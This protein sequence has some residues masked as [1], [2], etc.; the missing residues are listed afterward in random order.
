MDEEK[1]H[2]MNRA[3]SNFYCFT[4]RLCTQACAGDSCCTGTAATTSSRSALA[5]PAT[6]LRVA[7]VFLLLLFYGVQLQAQIGIYQFTGPSACPHANVAVTAQPA[8]ASFSN[9]RNQGGSCDSLQDIFNISNWNTNAT[10]NLSEYNEFTLT[11]AGGYLLDLTS[12]SF[13]QLATDDNNTKWCLRSSVDN[14]S[15]DIASGTAGKTLRNHNIPLNA[16]FTC[17]SQATFRFYIIDAKDGGTKWMMDNVALNGRVKVN[18]ATPAVP[19][20]TSPLCQNPGTT[21]SFNGLPPGTDNWYWQTVPNGTGIAN[22]TANFLVTTPGVYYLRARNKT[23]LDWS[24]ETSSITIASLTPDVA[25]PVFALGTSSDRCMGA[26]VMNFAATAQFAS[27]I[28]YSLDSASM[29]A[30]NSIDSTTG[31]V[32]FDSAWTG[33][34]IITA[35]AQ[36]CNGPVSSQH[37]VVTALPVEAPVFTLS[38]TTKRCQGNET[39]T[40]SATALHATGI[41]YSLDTASLAAGNSINA[42]T[43]EV[44]FAAGWFGIST[45]TATANG[46]FGPLSTTHVIATTASVGVPVF[47]VGDSSTRCVGIET[48][49][50]PATATTATGISYSLDSVSVAGGNSIDSTTGDVVFDAAWTGTTIVTAT[51]YGC[52][53]PTSAIHTIIT[54][55]SVTEPRFDAGSSSGRCQ[56]NTPVLYPVIVANATSIA[57]TL[58]SGSIAAGITIDAATGRATYPASWAGTTYITVVAEG[59]YGPQQ[60]VHTAIT[61][62]TVGTPVF[63]N[64]DTSSRCQGTGVV[65]IEATATTTTGITYSLDAAS[66]AAGNTIDAVT[67]EVNF[68]SSYSGTA[69]IT[70]SAAGCNGPA[71]AV[72]LVNVITTVGV[73][74]FASGATSSRCIGANI[75]TYTA[76]AT[77]ST[78]ITYSLDSAS[79]AAGNTIDTATG[80]VTWSNNWFGGSIITATAFGCN[81]PSSSEHVVTTNQEVTLPVFAVGDTSVRCQ[82]SDVVAYTATA[83]HTTGIVYTLDAAS[84]AAGNIIDSINGSITYAANWS[85]ITVITATANGCAGPK[86]ATHTVTT[87]ATVGLPVFALGATSSRCQAAGTVT[88]SADA[89]TNTGITYSLDSVSAAA[90]N[91]IDSL[92]GE[93]TYD[94][95]WFGSTVITATATGCNGPRFSTHTVTTNAPVTIPSFGAGDSTVRCEGAANVFYTATAENNTN[96]TYSIDAASISGGVTRNV[97]SG[98]VSFPANWSGTTIVTA[99]ATGCYGP[100]NQQHVVTT[101]PTVDLP[102]FAAGNTSTR[103]QGADTITFEA[104][105]TNATGIYYSLNASSLS[106]GNSI[107]AGTGEVIFVEGY[108]GTT[109]ITA[110]ADG[111]NGPRTATHT[112]TVTA[113]VGTPVFG[114]GATSTRCQGSG[115]V[116]YNATA[117]TNTGIS[118]TLDSASLAAGNTINSSTG[119]VSFHPAWNG[120]SIVTAIATGCNGPSVNTHTVTITPTVG[121]PVFAL[122]ASSERCR[123]NGSIQVVASASNSTS[124]SYQLDFLSRFSGNTI[125]STTGVVTYVSGWNGTSTITATAQGCN[126]PVTAVHTL[127]TNNYVTTPVF[128]DGYTSSRCQAAGMLSYTASASNTT[129]ITYS[130]D[131][132]SLAG[133]NTI[134]PVS[135]AVTYDANWFGTTIITATAAGCSGPRSVTHT[136]TINAPVTVPAFTMGATSV[137]CQGN[138]GVTYT[139]TVDHQTNLSYSLDAASLAAGNTI[140]TSTGRVVYTGSFTGTSVITARA[141]GCYG[142]QLQTH[143]VTTTPTVGTPVFTGGSSSVRCQGAGSVVYGATST[144]STGITYSLDA[145]SIAGGNTIDS[146]SGSVTFATNWNGTSVITARATGCNG[147]RSATHTVTITPTV[148]TPVYAAGATS[149]RCQAGGNVSYNVSA[150]NNTGFIYTLDSASL[151][152]GN[153]INAA[154]GVLTYNANWTGNSV[155]SVV[156]LGCNGPSAT[157]SHSVTTTPIVGVPEFAKGASSVRCQGAAAV[158]FTATAT[159]ATGITYSLN[160]ASIA[161]GNTINASTGTVT[162]AATWTGNSVITATAAGCSGPSVSVHTV[163]TTPTVGLPVF[164][165]GSSSSRCQAAGSTLYTANSTNNTGITYSLDGASIAGGNTINMT[166]GEVAY[167]AGWYGTTVVTATATGCNGP[168]SA[169]HTVVTNAPVTIPVFVL[170]GASTRCQGAGTVNYPAN[171]MHTTGIT[172]TLDSA[173]LAGGNTINAST[174]AVTY[175]AGWSGTSTITA[176]AAGCYGPQVAVH[177][178]TIT[179]TVGL[180]VFSSGST[181]ARCQGVE[182]ISYAAT[183]TN[184]TSIIYTL[185]GTSLSGGNTINSTTGVLTFAANWSGSSIITATA[186]G[187]NGPRSAS[188]VVATSAPVTTPVFAS[189]ATSTRCQGAGTINYS[190]TANNTTGITYMLDASS[191]AA[192]NTI[193]SNTGALT[194]TA[195]WSGTSIVTATA[196]GCYGPL[197]ATHIVTITPSVGTPFFTMG[198]TSSRCNGAGTVTYTATA[199]TNTGLTYSLDAGSIAAGNSINASTGTVTYVTGWVGIATITARATGCN[200]PITSIHRATSTPSVAVPV[201]T[202]GATSN[203]CQGAGMVT[204]QANAANST[205]I[206]YTIDGTSS[207]NGCTIDAS[208]GRVTYAAD[209]LGITTIT[210]TANGCNGPTVATHTVTVNPNGAPTFVLGPNSSRIQGAANVPFIANANNGSTVTYSLDAISLA[211]GNTINATTGVV[212]FHPL[213]IGFSEIT[214]TATG[215][216]GPVSATHTVMSASSTVTKQLY[217]SDPLHAL[218]RIDPV[219]TG[220]NTLATTSILSLNSSSI[221]IDNASSIS[222]TGSS[223]TI[224]HTTGS[225]PDRLMMV[226]ITYKSNGSPTS[227][228][229][230]QYV[231]YGGVVMNRVGTTQ[232]SNDRAVAIFSILNPAPGTAD[233]EVV[234]DIATTGAIIGVTTFTGVNQ[235]T[236]LNTFATQNGTNSNPSLT[237]ASA[238]NELVFSVVGANNTITPVNGDQRWLLVQSGLYGAGGTHPGAASANVSY[239]V[240]GLASLRSWI[241]SGISIRPSLGSSATFTQ[242]PAMCAP[243]IIKSNQL[244]VKTFVNITSGSMPA[245]PNISAVLRY[246]ATNIITLTNPA[247]NSTERSLTWTGATA[248]DV[249]VPAGQ[250]ISLDVVT[251]QTGVGFSIEYDSQDKPSRIELPVSTYIDINDLDVYDAPYPGGNLSVAAVLGSTRYIRATVSDPF[252][253]YD[254]TGLNISINPGGGNVT[255]TPVSSSGC[256]KV[257][258]Y[259]WRPVS[260]AN[261]NLVAT[262]KEGFEN[263][264]SATRSTNFTFCANCPPIALDD[265][266]SG[267]GGSPIVIDVLNNDYDPNGNLNPASIVIV[268]QPQNGDAVVSGGKIVYLPNGTFSGNDQFVYRVC[269][270]TSPTPLCDNATVFVSIDPTIV[271]PCSEASMSHVYYI[272][273]PEQDT[274]TALIK[275]TGPPGYIPI[276]SDNIRSII[277]IKILYPNMLIAWDHWEDGYESDITNPVQPSTKVW[278]DGNPYNGI[279]PGYSNDIIPPGGSI[280]LDNTIPSFPRLAANIFYDGR[281]KIFSS[282]QITMTQVSGEPSI[283]GLQC[284]KTN[285]SSTDDFGKSFTI[286]VGEDFPSQDFR[287]TALFIRAAENNTIVNIDKDRSGTFETTDTLNEGESMLVDGGVLT[288]ATV[289]SDKPVGVDLHIGGVDGY[290]SREVPI[291]PATW[292]SNVYYSPVPTTGAA[293]A[294]KDTAVVMLYNNLNRPININWSSGVPSS[295]T[296]A[297]PAKTAIRFPLALSS[298]AA[299]KFVNPT[300]E[301]FTAIEIVDSYTPGTGANSGSSYDWAFNLISEDRLTTFAAIAWAPGSTNGTRND[302]PIWV[303]PSANTTIYVKFDGDVLNGGNVSPCGLRYDVAYPLNALRHIRLRDT[304]N[305]Q[306]GLAVYTCDGTK[307]AAVYG[308]DPSTAASGAPSWDVGSTIRPYCAT[309][310]VI[311]TDDNAYTLTDRPVTIQILN[312]DGGFTAVVDPST[313][314]TTLNYLQPPKHGTVT[315]NPNG[316]LLYTPN[317]G[318]TGYDT[319]QYSVCSYPSPVVCDVAT[320]VI[321][322]NACPTPANKNIISGRVFTDLNKDGLFNDNNSGVKGAKVYLY[323]DGNCNSVGEANELKDSIVVDQSGSYQFIA[324][325]ENSIADDFENGAVSSCASGSDGTMPWRTNWVDA[326]DPSVGFCVT[327]AQTYTNT[328]AEIVRDNR[329]NTHALRVKNPSTSA[330]RTVNLTGANAAFISFSYR[331]AAALAA[332]KSVTV[333]VSSNGT[334]FATVFVINGNG[335]ADNAYIDVFNQDISSYAN[336][337]T[338]IRILTSPNMTNADTV[339]IDNITITYLKY[340][341]CYITKVDPTSVHPDFYFSTA[342][343]NPM[344]ATNG[345]TCLFP[346]DFGLAKKYVT[347][348]GTVYNDV[349]GIMDNQVN[350]VPTGAPS[351]NTL[352]A[353]LVDSTGKSAF[354][355]TVHSLTGAYSFPIAD[356]NTNFSV[357]IS[358][359]DSPLY[360]YPPQAANLPEGWVSTGDAY[361]L[362]NRAGSGLEADKANSRINVSTGLFEVTEVDFGIELLPTAG[363][364]ASTAPNPGGATAYNLP[365]GVFTNIKQS[366][367]VLPGTVNM[368]RITSFPEGIDVMTVNGV[369]YDRFTFPAEGLMVP[370]TS[371]GLPTQPI[372]LDPID[373]YVRAVIPYY[374]VDNA[375]MESAIPGSVIM[376]FTVD[377]DKDGVGDVDD[378]D[379]DNDGITDYVETCG[380]GATSFGCLPGGT[381]PSADDD[382]DG[383]INYRDPNWSPL[384]AVGVAIILDADVDGIPDYLDLDSDND[385]IPDVVEARGV[386]ANGDGIIDNFCDTDGDG[387]SQNVDANNTGKAGSGQGLGAPDFDGDGIVNTLDLDSDNDGV[388]DIVESFGTDANNDGRADISLDND[389]DGWVNDYDGDANGDGIV[390]N[391]AGVL[392]LTGSDPAYI[393]CASPGT[394]RPTCYTM[395]GNTD[396]HGLPNFIDLDSDGDGITDGRESG[397]NVASYNR[398]MVS[399]CPLVSGWCATVDA[400]VAL[401]LANADNHGKPDMY[402]IDSDNDGI[403]DN[404]EGQPTGS[405]VLPVDVDTDGDGVV[406]VYDFYP[407]IGANGITPYDH[408]ADGEPDYR[409]MDTDN[410]GAPDRN[411][412]DKRNAGL[413]QATINASPDKDGDGLVNYFDIY[414]YSIQFCGIVYQNV[415]MNNMGPNGSYHG[416]L[417]GGSNVTLVKSAANAPD[418]DWRNTTM[419]PLYVIHF[420]GK[421]NNTTADLVWKVENEQQVERYIVERSSDGANFQPIGEQAA[422]NAGQATYTFADALTNYNNKA[423]YY[424]IQQVDKNGQHFFTDIIVFNLGR[425]EQLVAKVYPN[426]VLNKLTVSIPSKTRQ[427]ATIIITDAAGKVVMTRAPMINAGD[428]ELL[429]DGVEGLSKGM[430]VV[431]VKTADIQSSFRI[432]KQ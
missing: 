269:D 322:V 96:I 103:C 122:G 342:S 428:N 404:V 76:S 155:V 367:D 28:S 120:T 40:F 221:A 399:G 245:M 94:S 328:N 169:N 174:G 242:A 50:Y 35:T 157:V 90:G 415:G 21:I 262:A 303:T 2:A 301:S 432:I 105:A 379:D 427:M 311:A 414:D 222:G 93:V 223:F 19:I 88:Y 134:D 284:M 193:N 208:T 304:D 181:S 388:P 185:D 314:S 135:G 397:I 104:T 355:T 171:A 80:T 97:N 119:A 361:G 106:A 370:V 215:C 246:G 117:S 274:R 313:V 206:T 131:N 74:V 353:Y 263:T 424:R 285:V 58:D 315:V 252:G 360:T 177:T 209:W 123:G 320:V 142:P 27:A 387:L 357:V 22:S 199:T 6:A 302:N 343:Q 147:P 227:N 335:Q 217:L 163:T 159:D 141:T 391:L 295:G 46:C 164:V 102:I 107:N 249:T 29:A 172:Y 380:A 14:F 211:A 121:T 77:A 59:C 305:D 272:P 403:T 216:N 179:P 196:H 64:G 248:S 12:L 423:V 326:G 173:S 279:A 429:I 321:L 73:P 426:P 175:T 410:D 81:G 72:H 54:R 99:T 71:T 140:N 287:Y 341:I 323:A 25:A 63:S 129:G 363:C 100:Q 247:Y 296:I 186:T 16:A 160:A 352:Y 7:V 398:G 178:V 144:N 422:S 148:G 52:N 317:I 300:G 275:S 39:V 374:A 153:T 92:T 369:A 48:I 191:L 75:F 283:I 115:T 237:L 224:P 68:A 33:S 408:D 95:A 5:V 170:N 3:L 78:N 229:S 395:R 146:T 158:A 349:N 165:A 101:T 334:S 346:F 84:M 60:Y 230:V 109:I 260:G 366:S 253:H 375:G 234:F 400:L 291:Y 113:T 45:I 168:R 130:L 261:Y 17:L 137:R 417:P 402:D 176:R 82:G 152:G 373:G 364:G 383:L 243:L 278:G 83:L 339:F 256:I 332:G 392:V 393:N 378:I 238:S 336:A 344:V 240:G 85:G 292:Y 204:Y 251:A 51:A 348:S 65:T 127:V 405:Q 20:I 42:L 327:P 430:Y 239:V 194:Y 136:V 149:T 233:V 126:G 111:C 288:G 306:S 241:M 319:L 359:I 377:T 8:N 316:T 133:G 390:E 187:C 312:N 154:T 220:D 420:S 293:T 189:G 347:I 351:G 195:G 290:S 138:N 264:V 318:F 32:T 197:V 298:T 411:E 79:V 124:I 307:L 416:P 167:A 372:T 86:T 389:E 38:D 329:F 254:I 385:G 212:T 281:D 180:P 161:G 36:G 412:G 330:T 225:G 244:R 188:H 116:T 10:I 255:A 331:K 236:P 11:A 250:S 340:P 210:A 268:S 201:F 265:S 213:W 15:T 67:G 125:N 371:T 56:G 162:F 394:G 108:N 114:A 190:A 396:N 431:Q 118:Y 338:Y 271:D 49:N 266:A 89:T 47:A 310:L 151:A 24:C 202:M 421:L 44:T 110:S 409:D 31:D 26:N 192:G 200:G 350:G 198:N 214:A 356:I 276:P 87:V 57:F 294:I 235:T 150:T 270:L 407:G 132:A 273:F 325:P 413:T 289:T 145:A 205:A 406:N 70:A 9:F 231:T 362:L 143:T 309:K 218:D 43:G 308:E 4:R 257:F 219:A 41:T 228:P 354:K 299:Y 358:T 337:A 182:A 232:S 18:V 282:G 128:D 401:N 91:S 53:G 267:A 333:Q 425:E 66:I 23:T 368:I 61:T 37:T 207:S 112:V 30:G 419:L 184:S 277:S 69:I 297:I 166:T 55:A 286:P 258:E 203:R 382:N 156:A 280:V 34:L 62:P 376:V 13:T 365:A 381:D 98:Q 226:G 139:A 183:S 345:G 1:E 418:R 324:Y 386:D 384:N 259:V